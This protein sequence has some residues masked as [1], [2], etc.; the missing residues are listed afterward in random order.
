MTV[1]IG[2]SAAK[3]TTGA[4]EWRLIVDIFLSLTYILFFY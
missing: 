4:K 2:E 1:T 3:A